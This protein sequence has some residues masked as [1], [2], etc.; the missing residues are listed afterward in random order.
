MLK[1]I[2]TNS[3]IYGISPFIPQ[4]V[5]ILILPII[6]QYLTETDYG[7]AGTINAYTGAIAVFSTL[8]MNMVL[9]PAFYRYREHY[10]WIWR[11]IYGFLQYWMIIFAIIQGTL[12]YFIIPV[13]AQDNRWTIIFLSNFATVFF[14]AT[15]LIGSLHYQLLQ[16]PLPIGIRSIIS[17]FI[18][19]FANLLF[20]VYFQWGYMGWYISGFI[21]NCFINLSYWKV[22]NK[23]WGMS[24]IYCFKRKRIEHSLKIAIPS[25][26]HYYS[27]FLLNSSNR[28]IMDKY[29]TPISEIGNFNFAA[30]FGNYFYA[31]TMA[32]NSAINPMAMEQIRLNREDI[33]KKLILSMV[34]I[35]FAATFIFSIWSKEIFLLLVKN[36]KLQN[37]YPIAIILVM[38]F[39]CRPMYVASSNLFFYYENTKGLLKISMVAG[40]LSFIGYLIAIPMWGIWGAV[41]VN[42]IAMQ[43]MGYSGFLMKEYKTK[44]KTNYP[45]K[46]ILLVNTTATVI[47]YLGVEIY[48]IFKIMITII[49]AIISLYLLKR[50][51][52]K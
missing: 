42:Y 51:N 17:G 10:K 1:K 21:A 28:L 23:T 37:V 27:N 24:P 19:I 43:Y 38:A 29:H 45:Y 30:Q 46:R 44:T 2:I 13:E 18:T 5:N 33:A 9:V 15:S 26:P 22:V 6:T 49:I 8:G 35:V 40:I 34:V 47:V 3:T 48:W 4:L 14:G 25:I 52:K 11:Q 12:L 31:L 20:V 50:L 41:I 39:N 7:I 36:A 32:L 16:Q